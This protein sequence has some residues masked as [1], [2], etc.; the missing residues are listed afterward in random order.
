MECK[1]LRETWFSDAVGGTD[2]RTLGAR[3]IGGVQNLERHHNDPFDRLLIAQAIHEGLTLVSVGCLAVSRQLLTSQARNRMDGLMWE[4]DV[5]RRK[6]T[7]AIASVVGRCDQTADYLVDGH[8]TERLVSD[9]K[10][11]SAANAHVG[12]DDT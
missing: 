4:L 3:H 12:D 11:S 1:R 6:L 8:R 2:F 7:A 9:T 5:V 10:R